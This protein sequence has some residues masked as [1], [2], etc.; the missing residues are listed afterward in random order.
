MG[1]LL[2]SFFTTS[3]EMEYGIFYFLGVGVGLE[4]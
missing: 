1:L 3:G 4:S 2:F